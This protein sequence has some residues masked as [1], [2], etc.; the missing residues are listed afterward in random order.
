[1]PPEGHAENC[2]Y[3][4]ESCCCGSDTSTSSV[5]CGAGQKPARSLCSIHNDAAQKEK[6]F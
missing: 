5:I 3:P 2:C 1:M 4:S 6:G